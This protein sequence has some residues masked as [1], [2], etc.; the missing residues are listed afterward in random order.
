MLLLINDMC[1][2]L[3]DNMEFDVNLKRFALKFYS[4]SIE[5]KLFFNNSERLY[6][7]LVKNLNI[8]SSSGEVE[9]VLG[10]C[11]ERIDSHRYGEM[12][13]DILNYITITKQ[14]ILSLLTS[15]ENKVYEP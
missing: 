12:F 14:L 6:G 15:L 7:Y 13:V 2:Y 1:E 4:M 3:I 5:Q 8:I 9:V 10:W 11:L